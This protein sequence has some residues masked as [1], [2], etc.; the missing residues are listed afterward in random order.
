VLGRPDCYVEPYNQFE[1]YWH[2]LEDIEPMGIEPS[3]KKG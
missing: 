3:G 2:L 1:D